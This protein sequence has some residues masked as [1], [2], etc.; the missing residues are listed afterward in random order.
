VAT[1]AYPDGGRFTNQLGLPTE[2][3][4][5]GRN[6]TGNCT[7]LIVREPHTALGRVTLVSINSKGRAARCEIDVPPDPTILRSL[8]GHLLRIATELEARPI[9]GAVVTA[10][11]GEASHVV[12]TIG[13]TGC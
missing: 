1:I 4:Y 11:A 7:G 8:A 2:S 6:G 12:E 13:A 3:L 10:G 5:V 9:A